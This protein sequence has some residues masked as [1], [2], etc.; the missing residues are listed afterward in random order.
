VR[1]IVRR[2]RLSY[3]LFVWPSLS[4]A[5][6]ATARSVLNRVVAALDDRLGIRLQ[7]VPPVGGKL[8][9]RTLESY[10]LVENAPSGACTHPGADI[11]VV[12]RP[13]STVLGQPK[14]EY[15]GIASGNR[16]AE[17][18][19]RRYAAV[20]VSR[21]LAGS[22]SDPEEKLYLSVL[23]ALLQA[24]T[25]LP[26]RHTDGWGGFFLVPVPH[27]DLEYRYPGA[28]GPTP[29]ERARGAA[30]GWRNY[31]EAILAGTAVRYVPLFD[32][33]EEGPRGASKPKA[34][35]IPRPTPNTASPAPH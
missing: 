11:T 26:T 28:Y 25:R 32:D 13:L 23:H 2:D 16:S 17:Q 27:C 3:A 5:H 7:P 8:V 34:G 21:V 31:L 29:E 18:P 10:G 1:A 22:S 30:E 4:P 19:P 15:G 35:A 20:D 12:F 14:A 6:L 24:L 9:H 33:P